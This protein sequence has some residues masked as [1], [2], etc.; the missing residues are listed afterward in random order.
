MST[1]LVNLLNNIKTGKLKNLMSPLVFKFQ[2]SNSMI[3]KEHARNKL[4]SLL[5][6]CDLIHSGKDILNYSPNDLP[7]DCYYEFVKELI[8]YT[9]DKDFC[10]TIF[11][12]GSVNKEQGINLSKVS[13]DQS[14]KN[15]D[16]LLIMPK[17]DGVSVG[18]EI[19][20]VNNVFKNQFD[21]NFATTR[22]KQICTLELKELISEI[23]ISE[24]LDDELL[25]GYNT[26]REIKFTGKDIRKMKIRG[27]FMLRT[28]NENVV[29]AAIAS[30]I[31]RKGVNEIQQQKNNLK[32]VCYE[33]AEISI[34]NVSTNEPIRVSV[35]Q[36]IAIKII[37]NI[38]IKYDDFTILPAGFPY[39]ELEQSKVNSFVENPYKYFE[40]LEKFREPL[41][42]LI[43]CN[44][45]WIYPLDESKFN[46]V[47]YGKLA[48]KPSIMYESFITGL[49]ETVSA[50]GKYSYAITVSPLFIDGKTYSKC[51]V[52]YYDLLDNNAPKYH[53][54]DRVRVVLVN[55]IGF[56]IHSKI[57][58]YTKLVDTLVDQGF[59]IIE[60]GKLKIPAVT[61]NSIVIT[62]SDGLPNEYI[63]QQALIDFIKDSSQSHYKI[64]SPVMF[65]KT[66]KS[67][68]KELFIK[69]KDV[70]CTNKQCDTQVLEQYAT[71]IS[72]LSKLAPG[73]LTIY[74]ESKTGFIKTTLNRKRLE[75]LAET[76]LNLTAVLNE[77]PN[78]KEIFHSLTLVNQCYC[79]QLGGVK[80]LEKL[81]ED[82]LKKMITESFLFR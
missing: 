70:Y 44:S 77:I 29:S 25:T 18:L 65:S 55:L 46:K 8:N 40:E 42:G 43:Y 61:P 76:G 39:Y 1:K 11:P 75:K 71:L 63:N 59:L 4:I 35:T 82:S 34:L 41:D 48:W 19:H 62:K 27:E 60:D 73:K 66:C 80:Q 21:I 10:N 52:Q 33:I 23:T 36:D 9:P 26:D 30:G 16:K 14:S 72:R 5:Q 49:Q 51:K 78:F 15:S 74:N 54:G 7:E 17:F 37:G 69:E 2:N 67:C 68:G 79:L 47:N 28:K 45:K 38:K 20:K 50:N 13:F 22:Q 31:L 24:L 57:Q 58:S 64:G 53:I 6:I 81:S 3:D 56:Q 12:M 32:L